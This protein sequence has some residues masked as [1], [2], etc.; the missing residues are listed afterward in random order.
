MRD[1]IFTRL[2]KADKSALVVLIQNLVKEAVTAIKA[3]KKRM[4]RIST[5]PFL[6]IVL[7]LIIYSNTGNPV[8]SKLALLFDEVLF[9]SRVLSIPFATSF[10][11][12]AT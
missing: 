12:S 7:Y 2:K 11:H 3:N 5:H 6:I 4:C 1:I 8:L 9:M 10:M